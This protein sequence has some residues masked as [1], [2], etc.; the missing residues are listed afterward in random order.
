MDLFYKL[1]LIISILVFLGLFTYTAIIFYLTRDTVYPPDIM[2]CPD[3]WKVTPEGRCKI[4]AVNELNLGNLAAKG[5]PIYVYDNITGVPKYSLLSEYY[6]PH[7][8]QLYKGRLDETLAPGFYN[9][10]IPYGYNQE[11][12]QI[13]S[14]D[15]GDPGWASYGDPQKEIQ[16]WKAVN[17][18]M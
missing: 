16:R 2:T 1:V 13:D 10:D 5:Q 18:I 6:D 15:F 4:P 14:I 8:N 7:M 9:A 12:P 17:N 3:Y 11:T